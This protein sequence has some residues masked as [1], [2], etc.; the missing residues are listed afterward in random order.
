MNDKKA[1]PAIEGAADNI[2]RANIVM[3]G[4]PIWLAYHNLI[5]CT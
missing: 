3:V 5:Q 4:F 1:R 2:Q